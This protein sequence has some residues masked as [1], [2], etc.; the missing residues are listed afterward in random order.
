MKIRR[1]EF[2]HK[3]S[4]CEEDKYEILGCP[5]DFDLELENTLEDMTD[6][7]ETSNLIAKMQ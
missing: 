3:T 1:I 4:N 5:A 2:K 6:E 7:Q